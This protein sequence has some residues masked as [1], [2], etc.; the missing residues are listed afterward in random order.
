[1]RRI[2]WS[3]TQPRLVV[4]S[5]VAVVAAVGAVVPPASADA[6]RGGLSEQRRLADRRFV[7]TGDR[8]YEVG[9]ADGRYPA[10]GWHIRG[11]MGGFWTPPI[12]LLDGM[13]FAVDGQ[14]LTRVAV[15]QRPGLRP[16]GADRSRRPAGRS[17]STSSPDGV[18]AA[19]VG[20]HVQRARAAAST[21]AVRRALGT[22]V[23]RTR[24]AGRRPSQETVN[25]PDTG[26]FDGRNLV[27]RETGTP[28]GRRAA[29][30]RRRRRQRAQPRTV[31]RSAPATAGRRSRP[32]SAR[33]PTRRRR[34]AT[35]ARTAGA[36]AGG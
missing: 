6:A 23:R 5:L 17:A 34:A 33:W 27:F 2:R 22:A 15:H 3:T 36:P 4:V 28:P 18:R 13:W 24:G 16:D 19:L 8:A 30:L 12:K 31:T 10:T 35:T 14:W 11:E 1:M 26:G 21:L 25:L 7:A 20:L 29:R 32:W 9:A